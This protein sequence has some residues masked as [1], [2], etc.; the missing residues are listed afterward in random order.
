VVALADEM[1]KYYA[2]LGAA[3]LPSLEAALGDFPILIA[4]VRALGERSAVVS[5]AADEVA[6]RLET[7]RAQLQAQRDA[8]P[9]APNGMWTKVPT[10]A[11]GRPTLV[12]LPD[13]IGK[14]EL[15]RRL[16]VEE[17]LTRNVVEA[18]PQLFEVAERLD[19]IRAKAKAERGDAPA[20]TAAPVTVERCEAAVR[21]IL[22]GMKAKDQTPWVDCPTLLPMWGPVE[23]TDAALLVRLDRELFLDEAARKLRRESPAWLAL[24]T[25]RMVPFSHRT[26]VG[27]T[28]AQNVGDPD[29]ILEAVGDMQDA[30]CRTTTAIFVH[31]EIPDRDKLDRWLATD[32]TSKP[33]QAWVDEA[34]ARPRAAFDGMGLTLVSSGPAGAIMLATAPWAPLGIVPALS[35]PKRQR[36]GR[37]VEVQPLD[38]F[39]ADTKSDAPK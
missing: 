17:R 7:I 27:V 11:R 13:A 19:E 34:T 30:I 21:T 8:L 33:P 2:D 6:G 31:A 12:R 18:I 15:E 20:Q 35:D 32:C 38:A 36:P 3:S 24:Q 28:V 9:A 10:A 39:L 4:R 16:Q 1:A 37:P 22:E 25:G 26:F 23:L 14:D 29:F 5:A